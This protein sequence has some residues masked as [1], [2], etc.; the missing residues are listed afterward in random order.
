MR[1]NLEVYAEE[2]F[3][4]QVKKLAAAGKID[5]TFPVGGLRLIDQFSSSR[6]PVFRNSRRSGGVY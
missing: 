1:G 2:G 4:Q 6:F 5:P 3:A